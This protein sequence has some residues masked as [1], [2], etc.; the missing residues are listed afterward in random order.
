MGHSRM[1]R[2]HPLLGHRQDLLPA[3]LAGD[4]AEVG[5]LRRLPAAVTTPLVL[6]AREPEPTSGRQVVNPSSTQ[7]HLSP[8]FTHS[9]ICNRLTISLAIRHGFVTISTLIDCSTARST[10]PSSVTRR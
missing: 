1:S 5:V 9:P 3:L 7:A 6:E 8:P 4:L 2:N 10:S